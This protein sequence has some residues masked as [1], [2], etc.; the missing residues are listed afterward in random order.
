MLWLWIIPGVIVLVLLDLLV[1]MAMCR[2]AKNGDDM[3]A[4]WVRTEEQKRKR[5]AR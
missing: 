4:R 5:E 2:A 1:I 3:M